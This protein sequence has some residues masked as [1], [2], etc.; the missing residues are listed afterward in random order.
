M[1][2]IF[3]SIKENHNTEFVEQQK[4]KQQQQNK[5]FFVVVYCELANVEMKD[6]TKCEKMNA[7]NIESETRKN[8]DASLIFVF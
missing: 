5:E 4:T 3:F 1:T 7:K 6:T 2:T 8:N